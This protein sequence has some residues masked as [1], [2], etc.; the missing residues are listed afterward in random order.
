MKDAYEN[1][2]TKI[3]E[4]RYS[5]DDYLTNF[6]VLIAENENTFEVAQY[7]L[8]AH[9]NTRLESMRVWLESLHSR[10]SIRY[11]AEVL[12]AKALSDA[13]YEVKSAKDIMDL[14]KITNISC[15]T[16]TV[17]SAVSYNLDNN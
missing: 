12:N 16:R 15:G 6:S 8:L 9:L 13:I 14:R 5:S 7:Q 11:Q 4:V 3:L 1:N 2:V 17:H 10:M